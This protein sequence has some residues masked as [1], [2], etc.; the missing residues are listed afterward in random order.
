MNQVMKNYLSVA[1]ELVETV[2]TERNRYKRDV[3]VVHGLE[4]D[5]RVS[6]VPCGFIQKVLQTLQDLQHK[7][8]TKTLK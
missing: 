4:L 2:R 6:A 1:A 7:E 8:R 5:A 3:R